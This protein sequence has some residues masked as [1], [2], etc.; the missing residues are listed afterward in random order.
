MIYKAAA[1]LPYDDRE[2]AT[3]GLRGQL[4]LMAVCDDAT[5]DWT[6]LNVAGPTPSPGLHGRT[7]FEWSATVEA[8]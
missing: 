6:T 3:A 8:S 4:R 2:R 7:W 1:A 5:P